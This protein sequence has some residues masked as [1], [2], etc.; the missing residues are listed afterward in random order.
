[1]TSEEITRIADEIE[2]D[3]NAALDI[4]LETWSITSS[5]VSIGGKFACVAALRDRAAA[6]VTRERQALDQAC[7]DSQLSI[8]NQQRLDRGMRAL[9][10]SEWLAGGGK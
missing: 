2:R 6:A 7:Y 8:V 5:I 1:M 4:A 9:T 3:A 10:M